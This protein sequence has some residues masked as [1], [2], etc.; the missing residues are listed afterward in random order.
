MPFTSFLAFNETGQVFPDYTSY[1]SRMPGPGQ[2]GINEFTS[3][4]NGYGLVQNAFIPQG[5]LIPGAY[6]LGSVNF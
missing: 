3:L 2:F 5:E 1:Y 6:F 4:P